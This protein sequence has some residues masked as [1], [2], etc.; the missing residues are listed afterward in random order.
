MDTDALASC[1][2]VPPPIAVG[3][4]SRV[5]EAPALTGETAAATTIA[6]PASTAAAS[7]PAA[8][9]VPPTGLDALGFAVLGADRSGDVA[10]NAAEADA[11]GG[12]QATPAASA[13]PSAALRGR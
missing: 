7:A 11:A 6:A 4:P 3:S 12:T 13:V 1:A 5:A 2:G 9:E 10:G 8:A